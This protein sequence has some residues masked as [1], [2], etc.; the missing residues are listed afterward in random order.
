[1]TELPAKVPTKL[2]GPILVP[3]CLETAWISAATPSPCHDLLSRDLADQFEGAKA[4]GCKTF[5][6]ASHLDGSKPLTHRAK[7][8]VVRLPLVQ[9]RV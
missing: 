1:M 5:F 6:V 8:G 2:A 7:S 3:R 9:E 4:S